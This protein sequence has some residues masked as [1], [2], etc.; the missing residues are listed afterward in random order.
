M[1]N[2]TIGEYVWDHEDTTNFSFIFF[3]TS[4]SP[5]RDF[6][7]NKNKKSLTFTEIR[8][9]SDISIVCE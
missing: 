8:E 7:K 5:F 1:M 4:Y 3:S 9:T 2:L 6:R